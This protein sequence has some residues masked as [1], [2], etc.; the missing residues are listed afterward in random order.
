MSTLTKLYVYNKKLITNETLIYISIMKG[1][2][3]L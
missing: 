3:K 1:K 2:I